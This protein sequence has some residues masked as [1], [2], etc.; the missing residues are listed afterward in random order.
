[1]AYKIRILDS[2]ARKLA[3]WGLSDAV[4]VDVYLRLKDDLPQIPL[5]K[6]QRVVWPY[7]GM[8]YSFPLTDPEP[9]H[10]R[11][12]FIFHVKYGTDE[13]TLLVLDG[14]FLVWF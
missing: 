7:D 13:E 1:M 11:R 14:G 12:L 3:S 8:V 9:P 6:L 10:Q 2:V 5:S 4:L